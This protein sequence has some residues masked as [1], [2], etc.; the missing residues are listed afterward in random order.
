[1]AVF[2]RSSDVLASLRGFP[3]LAP[4]SVKLVVFAAVFLKAK[5]RHS[6]SFMQRQGMPLI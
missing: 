4:A 2:L 5:K 3:F 6:S 1:M